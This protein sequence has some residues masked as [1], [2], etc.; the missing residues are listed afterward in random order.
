MP[1]GIGDLVEYLAGKGYQ[2]KQ[3]TG[4]EVRYPCFFDCDEPADSRKRKLY[5]NTEEGFYHCKVCQARGGTTLLLR[6]FGDDP[7][8]SPLPS[9]DWAARRR[10]LDAATAVGEQVLAQDDDILLELIRERGLSEQTIVERRLGRIN[11][12]RSL[13][14]GLEASA[15]ELD[16]TGLVYRDG[17]RKGQDFFTNHVLIPYL[18]RGQVVQLRGKEPGGKYMTGPGESVRLFNTDSLDDA[19]DVIIT[20]GEFDCIALEQHLRSC[21]EDR[22]RTRTGVVGVPGAGSLPA[23]FDSYLSGARRVFIGF[24]PDEPGKRFAVKVKEQLGSRAR[25][26]ELPET[27]PKCDWTEFLLPVPADA[28]GAWHAKHPHAGHTWRDV[29]DLLSNAPGKRVFSVG[30]AARKWHNRENSAGLQ[31]GWSELDATIHPG[32]LPGQLAVLLAKTGVGKT[33]WLCNLAYNARLTPTLFISLEQTQEEVYERLRRIYLFH[34][35]RATDA[36]IEQAFAQ[37]MICDEN[38]L[39]EADMANLIDEFEVEAGMRPELVLVDYLGYYAKGMSGGTP[40]EKTSNAVMQLKA[41]AKKHRV[42]VVAPHQVNRLAKEGK[43][44]SIDDARDSGV[45]EETA[46][47]MLSIFRPDDALDEDSEPTGKL[48][49][50]LN[51]SRHGGKGKVFS[52]QMDLLTLAVVDDGTD[53]SR[54]AKHHSYLC[55]RGMTY[56]ALRREQTKPVQEAIA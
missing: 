6:H 9:A 18:S 19:E 56:D 14:G 36:E 51:K 28:D 33:I 22:L 1:E 46:D 13:V 7:G 17:P 8:A 53:E 52:L 45:V 26:I 49:M 55:W 48:R 38:R 50:E 16:N 37:T 5:L 31:T 34:E 43:P 4:P 32:M 39:N 21:P 12:R 30:D 3:A 10:I 23:N 20:E 40:Y 27:L 25:I 24:D 2:A 35:P 11:G 47:Y 15:A 42:I 29:A 54:R 44:L 41:E